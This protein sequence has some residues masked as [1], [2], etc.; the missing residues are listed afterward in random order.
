MCFVHSWE[1]AEKIHTKF[2]LLVWCWGLATEC[3]H[4]IFSIATSTRPVPVLPRKA[5]LPFIGLSHETTIWNYWE[6]CAVRTD[7]V[8]MVMLPFGGSGS[9][10]S[11]G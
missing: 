10:T 9:T 4:S 11:S 6:K 5:Q 8:W 1:K 3:T 2:S 7:S